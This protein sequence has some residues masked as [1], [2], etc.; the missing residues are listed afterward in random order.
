MTSH[1]GRYVP[2]LVLLS[3]VACLLGI[4]L[5]TYTGPLW[6]EV[7]AELVF[8]AVVGILF[9]SVRAGVYA[10]RER[11]RIR[12]LWRTRTVELTEISSITS[13]PRHGDDH[14]PLRSDVLQIVL[15]DGET[16]RTPLR[17]RN[18]LE[19]TRLSGAVYERDEYLR[20]K[21]HLGALVHNRALDDAV[22]RR[23]RKPW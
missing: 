21:S 19:G 8:V 13:T 14:D 2:T 16:I 11:L 18:P 3:L 10:D 1:Q 7:L 6:P 4:S 22:P 15:K 20:I 5:L 17:I 12:S 9:R 23:R